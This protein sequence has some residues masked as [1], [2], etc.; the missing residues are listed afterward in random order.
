M[1]GDLNLDFEDEGRQKCY[2]EAVVC[3]VET[4]WTALM[5]QKAILERLIAKHKVTKEDL[6]RMMLD[7]P[8]DILDCLKQIEIQANSFSKEC[9]E[10]R[11]LLCDVA[12]A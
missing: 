5:S 7:P 12:E 11:K 8:Q 3:L 2:Q 1:L 4:T 6:N 9:R 10:A